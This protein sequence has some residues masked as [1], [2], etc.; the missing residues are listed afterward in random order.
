MD[1]KR[2]VKHITESKVYYTVEYRVWYT[3]YEYGNDLTFDTEWLAMDFLRS[4][5][6]T[7]R[8]CKA[9][10]KLYKKKNIPFVK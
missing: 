6:K 10:Q 3:W 5:D 2:V 8:E 9:D 7:E 4:K 1:K